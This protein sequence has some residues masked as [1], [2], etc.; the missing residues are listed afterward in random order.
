MLARDTLISLPNLDE[1]Q[2][3]PYLLWP[4]QTQ[5]KLQKQ[6]LGSSKQ[7]Q[8]QRDV[9]DSAYTMQVPMCRSL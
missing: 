9:K 6:G 3:V 1:H 8:I 4:A 2:S 5:I 7:Q